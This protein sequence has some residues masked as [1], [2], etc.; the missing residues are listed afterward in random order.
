MKQP[1]AETADSK[2]KTM[3]GIV[4][5]YA[6]SEELGTEESNDSETGMELT[7]QQNK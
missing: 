4:L 1:E 2:T 3:T 6:A 7:F 5:F